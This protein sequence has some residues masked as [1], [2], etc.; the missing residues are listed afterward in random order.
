MNYTDTRQYVNQIAM[1]IYSFLLL[2][3]EEFFIF[4]FI[5]IE[6]VLRA[7]GQKSLVFYKQDEYIHY[8]TEVL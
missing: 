5:L 2:A 4:H 1:S 7:G 3:L 6:L 8:F